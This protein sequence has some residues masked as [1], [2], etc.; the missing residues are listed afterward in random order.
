MLNLM[1]T[2]LLMAPAD[3]HPDKDAPRTLI[4]GHGVGGYGGTIFGVSVLD[5][6]PG[7]RFGGRGGWVANRSFGIGVFGEAFSGTAEG[8][9]VNS[10]VGGLYVEGYLAARAPVHGV[11]EAGVGLGDIAWGDQHGLGFTPFAAVRLE[12]NL[13]TWM[14]AAV[15]PSAHMLVAQDIIPG[16]NFP[17]T[18]GGDL[19]FKFGAF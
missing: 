11:I 17:A 1:L 3:A 10:R 14:R 9:P 2:T 19:V 5:G 6:N 4:S 7:T 12:L 18:F 15:G 13:V 8:V 16:G